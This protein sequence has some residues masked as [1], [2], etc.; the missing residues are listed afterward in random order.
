MKWIG[1]KTIYLFT[2]SMP[3]ERRNYM[4][5]GKMF[6][7]RNW[8]LSCSILAN[9]ALMLYI[10]GHLILPSNVL[11]DEYW[12]NQPSRARTAT[13]ATLQRLK[14]SEE[15]NTQERQQHFMH[16]DP[17]SSTF[18]QD[19]NQVQELLLIACPFAL[20]FTQAC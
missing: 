7:R 16:D 9:I 17:D 13:P 4:F 8:R 11:L 19:S 5:Q 18:E 20:M 12:I 3:I 2:F 10:C 15:R 6:T 14:A 1:S